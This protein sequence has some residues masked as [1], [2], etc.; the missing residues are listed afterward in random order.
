V[1]S[2]VR[3]PLWLHLYLASS[4]Q[5]IVGTDSRHYAMDLCRIFPPDANFTDRPQ[6]EK[7]RHKMAVLRPE[8]L[9]AYLK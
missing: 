5:G 4:V 6:E 7:W 9:D 1:L 8:C 3:G 2:V